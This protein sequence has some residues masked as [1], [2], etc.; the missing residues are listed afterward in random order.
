[1]AVKGAHVDR[2]RNSVRQTQDH[3]IAVCI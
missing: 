3:T 1:M 2:R